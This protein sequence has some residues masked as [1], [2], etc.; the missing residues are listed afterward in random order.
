MR[1]QRGLSLVGLILIGALVAAAAMVVIKVTPAYVEY[2]TILKNVKAVVKSG[3]AQGTVAD[4]RKAYERRETIDDTKSVGAKD[5]D[6]TK[7]GGEVIISFAY[8]KKIPL[9]ANVSV[10]LDFEGSSGPGG[11]ET[12]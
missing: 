1:T 11:R 9:F 12:Q 7:S 4:I 5:L 8:S 2:Y 6:I 10:C 3:E